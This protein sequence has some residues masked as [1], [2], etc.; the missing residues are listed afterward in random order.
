MIWISGSGGCTVAAAADFADFDDVGDGERCAALDGPAP[1]EPA[2]LNDVIDFRPVVSALL[3]RA[4]AC[5]SVDGETMSTFEEV[6]RATG[7]GDRGKAGGDD[8]AEVL[9]D[10]S[11]FLNNVKKET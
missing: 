11:E 1:V 10:E 5:R 2:E 4:A 8:A 6:D 3:T 9:A 7:D